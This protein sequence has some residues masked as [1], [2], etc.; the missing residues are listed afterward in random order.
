MCLIFYNI[1]QALT[2]RCVVRIYVSSITHRYSDRKGGSTL[3]WAWVPG[4]NSNDWSWKIIVKLFQLQNI[5][6]WLTYIND[7]IM[8]QKGS[9]CLLCGISR[10][11]FVSVLFMVTCTRFNQQFSDLWRGFEGVQAGFLYFKNNFKSWKI[12]NIDDNK[13][14]CLSIKTLVT[15]RDFSKTFEQEILL[16]PY[17][18]L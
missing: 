5:S 11:Q 3:A 8:Y 9:Y 1:Q 4:S 14:C 6:Y 15:I 7:T 18:Q 10:Q 17:L 2:S 13:E 16:T 12:L